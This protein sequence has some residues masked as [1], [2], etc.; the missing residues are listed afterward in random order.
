MAAAL[1]SFGGGESEFAVA[2]AA[3]SVGSL[4][5]DRLEIARWKE[6]GWF[7][8]KRKVRKSLIPHRTFTHWPVFW[9]AVGVAGFATFTDVH[10]RIAAVALSVGAL[11]HILGDAM[12]PMGVPLWNPLGRKYSLRWVRSLVAEWLIAWGFLAS[13]VAIYVGV[14]R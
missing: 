14:V 1:R 13:S 12:T 11:V 8:N 6:E 3:S 9:I 10:L 2:V 7:L 4:L 5:P